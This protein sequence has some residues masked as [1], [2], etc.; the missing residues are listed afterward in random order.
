MNTVTINCHLIR[1][2]DHSKLYK[3]T[4]KNATYTYEMESENIKLLSAPV[5]MPESYQAKIL[6]KE[7]V[8]NKEFENY[9]LVVIDKPLSPEFR[10]KSSDEDSLMMQ[11]DVTSL[12][13]AMQFFVSFLQPHGESWVSSLNNSVEC[14]IPTMT[15]SA[16]MEEICALVHETV[17]AQWNILL[18]PHSL[19]RQRDARFQGLLSS[20]IEIYIVSHLHD[21]IFPLMVTSLAEKDKVVYAKAKEFYDLGV[22]ADQFG[23]PEDFAVPLPAA[24]VE[25]A[26]IDR[27]TSPAEKLTCLRTTMDLIMAEIK[28]AIVDAHSVLSSGNESWTPP[29]QPGSCDLIPLIMY[30]LVQAKPLHLASNF[31]YME[32]LQW[33]LEPNNVLSHSLAAFKNAARELL[34]TNASELL[35]KSKKIIR[36]LSLEDLIKV[37]GVVDGRFTRD[38]DRKEVPEEERG[39][40]SPLDRQLEHLTSMIE[41]ST[42]ELDA[43]EM[44]THELPSP[45]N[46]NSEGLIAVFQ[47]NFGTCLSKQDED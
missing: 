33:T 12:D 7:T 34:S 21:Y 28:G 14:L 15:L 31:F 29:I 40:F 22:T 25:L 3:S 9:S 23:A 39:A 17:A 10:A 26:S 20:A 8:Y 16:T 43:E 30:V 42:R 38:G 2:S 6:E 11:K 4:G 18:R 44:Q 47:N 13:E 41:A 35:P 32:N 45:T 1:S 19:K 27:L 5:P 24:V 37:T 46:S 36:E